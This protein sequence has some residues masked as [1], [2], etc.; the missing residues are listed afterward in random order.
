MNYI[1]GLFLS[2][3]LI[4]VPAFAEVET[5]SSIR[6]TVN[7]AGAAV[8]ITNQSTGQTKSVT[9]GTT[10]N[11]SA[12]FLKVGGPYSV[13][14]SAPGYARPSSHTIWFTFPLTFISLPNSRDYSKFLHEI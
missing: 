1:K 8:E 2:I 7:V 9:A 12:S 14:A 13:S 11:F 3:L 4:S 6:G 10:G 5:T